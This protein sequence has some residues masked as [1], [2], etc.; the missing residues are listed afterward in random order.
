MIGVAAIVDLLRRSAADPYIG[1][2]ISQLEHAL[3]SA[4]LASRAGAGDATIAA[5]LLHDIG[6]LCA[7]VD[8]PKMPG[9]GVTD[10]E[11]VGA[12]FLRDAG[13]SEDVVALVDG[14]VAAKRYLVATRPEYAAK[15]SDASRATLALQGGPMSTA[16]V[17]DFERSPRM[18]DLLRLR[19]WDEQAKV[20]GWTGP[21][22]DSWVPLLERLVTQ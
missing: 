2:P 17:A 11:H 8:A 13:F 12:R 1:E 7:S 16:E 15:L 22:L 10:H 21:D 4:A 20:V 18:K 14:H 5:A 6:H 9:L 3:Q 19:A